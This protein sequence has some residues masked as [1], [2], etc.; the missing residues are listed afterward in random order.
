MLAYRSIADIPSDVDLAV[1]SLPATAVLG[2]AEDALRKGV[3]A[4]VVISA[5]FAEIGSEGAAPGR[6]A[7]AGTR[8]THG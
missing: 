1:I 6:A 2:A 4:L 8:L 7:G 5:G 3:K